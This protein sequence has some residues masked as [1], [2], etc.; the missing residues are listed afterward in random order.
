[1]DVRHYNVARRPP[2]ASAALAIAIALLWL[3]PASAKPWAPVPPCAAPI[4]VDEPAVAE[5]MC[6]HVVAHAGDVVVREY[7][8]P[9]SATL[10]TAHVD[11]TDFYDA[12]TV[13]VQQILQ[14]FGGD[15]AQSANIVSSRTTPITMR[16][17]RDNNITYIIG[18]MVS[19]ANFPNN[20][21]VPAP[22]LPVML[23]NVGARSIA[24]LQ[25]NTSQP[26]VEADFA[27]ACGRL[28][29][30]PLPKGYSFDAASSWTPT[31]VLYNGEAALFFTN[32]CW[33]E[34]VRA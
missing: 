18:M 14:Y 6:S 31:Y 5:S 27:A 13:G 2:A 28:L 24:A 4:G 10:V 26:P 23:E 21:T 34:V 8:L 22:F 30:G 11:S 19:T 17:L 25:F 3:S 9:A 20:A 16:D 1:M 7:G 33:A 12:L 32:E 15:N 29:A